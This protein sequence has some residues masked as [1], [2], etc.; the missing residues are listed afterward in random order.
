MS[1]PAFTP[2]R[3]SAV[4]QGSKAEPMMNVLAERIS[5]RGPTHCVA[6]CATG[7]S[8]QEMETA[9]AHLISAAPDMYEAL[10]SIIEMNVQY[11]I[12]RY[13]DASQAED[14]A[15]VRVARAALAKADGAQ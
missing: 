12:D 2:G 11:A 5:G 7:D 14:M 3:W 8:A 1:K 10:Q 15:C 4:N 13:G 6:I 9:N